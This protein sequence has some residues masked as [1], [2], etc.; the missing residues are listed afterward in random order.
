MPGAASCSTGPPGN[1]KTTLS[2]RI[3]GL[4]KNPVHIPYAVEIAGQ[5]IRVFDAQIHQPRLTETQAS[6]I[7]SVC[8]GPIGLT[9]EMADRRW[10]ACSLLVVM[11]GGEMALDM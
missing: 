7:G 4:F 3:A 6:A 11:T 10:V 5:I 2:T 1:G 9:R 8:L